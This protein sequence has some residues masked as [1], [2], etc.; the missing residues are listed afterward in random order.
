MRNLVVISSTPAMLLDDKLFLDIKFVEGM[1]F[2][3][4]I[5]NG[6][7]TCILKLQDNSF[8]FGRLFSREELSFDV[9]LISNNR[10]VDRYNIGEADLVL[11]SGEDY[12]CFDLVFACKNSRSKIVYVIENIPETRRRIIFLERQRSLLKKLYSVLWEARQEAKR[13]EA[14]RLADGIQANGY[15]AHSLYSSLN[16]NSMMFLDN[17]LRKE[18]FVSDTEMADRLIRL[19]SGAPLRLVHSG[20]LETL[21]GSQDLIPIARRLQA[22]GVDFT[23][24]IF[25]AGSLKSEIQQG[26]E[27]HCLQKRVNLRGE[28]DFQ[29]HLV[30]FMRSQADIYL[31]CHRQSDPS[32]TYIENMG[33]GV[34]V[35]GY[36]NRMWSALCVE[37]EAGWVV[38]MGKAE[39]AAAAIAEADRNRKVLGER[40]LS[41][42][43]FAQKHSFENEFIRRIEHLRSV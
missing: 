32:C 40:C 25:G 1:R 7:V 27:R 29:A 35:V 4:S 23:L 37:S 19:Q 11:V 34:A 15:P 10:G 13:R 41:A 43:E 17:R 33:C 26:I 12:D 20:R 24:D 42:K 18:M 22:M 38:P 8:P 31:S 39:K 30:P 2:Y 21:K 16:Q 5:W 14:F 36:D 28:V 3:A 6:P 9:R